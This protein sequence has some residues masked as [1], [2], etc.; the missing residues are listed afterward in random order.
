MYFAIGLV[1]LVH[2]YIQV[3]A[4]SIGCILFVRALGVSMW[5]HELVI[6]LQLTKLVITFYHYIFN[7]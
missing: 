1:T 3:T 6:V 2:S 5:K 4:T 7:P